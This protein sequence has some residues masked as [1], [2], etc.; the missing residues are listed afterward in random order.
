MKNINRQNAFIQRLH[1]RKICALTDFNL[2]AR[3]S[4]LFTA[5]NVFSKGAAFVFTPIFTRLLTE[6]EYGE[7]SVRCAAAGLCNKGDKS[8]ILARY[9]FVCC[10]A[11]RDET[12]LQQVGHARSG[13]GLFSC[14][15]TL[16]LGIVA[17]SVA[18]RCFRCVAFFDKCRFRRQYPAGCVLIA[19]VVS[20]NR[21]AG[22]RD[23]GNR[24]AGHDRC[25]DD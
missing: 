2:P 21:D 16:V 13:Q 9:P 22:N 3:S 17:D 23:A 1:I 19:R 14:P 15:V 24:D 7:Y 20:R 8:S 6:A 4:V 25:K 12:Q 5:I 18:P 10:S 11:A